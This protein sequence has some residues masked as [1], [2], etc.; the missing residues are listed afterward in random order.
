V[1]A[2]VNGVA[3]A[4]QHCKETLE[5]RQSIGSVLTVAPCASFD[6]AFSKNTPC[7]VWSSIKYLHCYVASR[8]II[9]SQVANSFVLQYVYIQRYCSSHC[10]CIAL[11]L[12][13][14]CELNCADNSI[15]YTLV[16]SYYY[17]ASKAGHDQLDRCSRTSA[18]RLSSQ[19]QKRRSSTRRSN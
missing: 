8:N 10:I 9:P 13:T 15:V 1:K 3:R 14:E 16:A 5:R 7:P 19:Q 2:R 4:Y 17:L 12:Q 18:V 6:T 11:L